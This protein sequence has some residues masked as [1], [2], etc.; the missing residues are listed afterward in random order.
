MM[1]QLL[2]PILGSI[3]GQVAKSLFPD[4]ADETKR[5]EVEKSFAVETMKQAQAIE[6]AAADIVKAEAQ[7]E[8]WLASSWRPVTMLI[9]VG[10]IVARWFGWAA[11][12][13][14][15][16]EYIKLWSIVELGLGGYVIGRSAEKILPAVAATFRKG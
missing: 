7:S 15:E 9:F 4:P 16:E 6:Q 1:L 13:L 2:L 14:A 8:N 5:M 12:N 10:L 11:P 3:G